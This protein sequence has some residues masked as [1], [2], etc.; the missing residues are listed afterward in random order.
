MV[1]PEDQAVHLCRDTMSNKREFWF[2]HIAAWRKG[3][4][5]RR[6]ACTTFL[7]ISGYCT[8]ISGLQFLMITLPCSKFPLEY[9]LKWHVLVAGW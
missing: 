4:M 9:S 6:P 3:K 2:N 7:M 5:A 8:G 1:K